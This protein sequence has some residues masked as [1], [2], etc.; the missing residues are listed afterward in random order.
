VTKT[1][2][3]TREQRKKFE[4]FCR[5]LSEEELNRPVPDSTWIVKDFVSHLGS[6]DPTLT[7]FFKAT[8]AG[9]PEEE[10]LTADGGSL[11]IDALNDELVAERREWPVERILGEAAAN[12]TDLIAALEAISEEDV[13]RV[14][15]FQGDN[16]RSPAQMP[17]KVFLAGWKMHDA[18]HA[19]DMLKALPQR[20]EDPEVRA[21]MNHPMIK[22]YQTAMAGPSRR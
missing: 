4:A 18:I 15:N 16:K 3:R 9:R 7:Q 5:S 14:M 10:G 17:L 6:L 19:A 11:D 2:E 1:I 8:A 22:G 12:R 20:A 21:W 13:S